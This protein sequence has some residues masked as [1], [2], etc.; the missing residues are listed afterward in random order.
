MEDCTSFDSLLISIY[1]I[2]SRLQD[3]LDDPRITTYKNC[4]SLRIS[5]IL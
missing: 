4:D 5:F 1:P 3:F 2:I